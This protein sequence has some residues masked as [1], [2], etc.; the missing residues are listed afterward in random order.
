MKLLNPS[1]SH[2]PGSCNAGVSAAASL[3]GHPGGGCQHR[4]GGAGRRGH[5]RGL[6]GGLQQG[7]AR[8][9]CSGGA[10]AERGAVSVGTASPSPARI[11]PGQAAPCASSSVCSLR[12]HRL[13]S[14]GLQPVPQL[15]LGCCT[16][17]HPRVP[18]DGHRTGLS[19]P[20]SPSCPVTFVAGGAPAPAW[21]ARALPAAC[22][23]GDV[24]QERVSQAC[25][26]PTRG[27]AA[28]LLCMQTRGWQ[29]S[30]A[31]CLC[32]AIRICRCLQ[33]LTS[34]SRG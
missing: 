29:L 24:G 7:L 31:S 17:G 8:A 33:R 23:S 11:T 10:T 20:L 19:P 25:R 30:A 1:G 26:S 3:R 15:L 16:Q 12:E 22:R 34:S 27:A 5:G 32:R 21:R 13:Q 2:I 18:L 14:G 6:G 9:G 28:R 4:A